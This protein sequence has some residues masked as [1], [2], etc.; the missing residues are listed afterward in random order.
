MITHRDQGKHGNRARSHGQR[1][2]QH[3]RGYPANAPTCQY[4]FRQR[5]AQQR[6]RRDGTG[7]RN[8]VGDELQ[9]QDIASEEREGHGCQQTTEE[10]A[11]VVLVRC[12]DQQR[13]A[14][15][16]R[17]DLGRDAPDEA[18]LVH[19]LNK[20]GARNKSGDEKQKGKARELRYPAH[21]GR[22]E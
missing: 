6:E 17:E 18:L 20:M 7:R 8:E 19:L 2:D 5:I 12:V 1:D 15:S 3:R 9:R 13:K 4:H 22:R 10:R 11:I 21:Y 16:V 14:D